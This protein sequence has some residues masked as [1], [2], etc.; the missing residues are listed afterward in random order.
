VSR[1]AATGPSGLLIRPAAPDEL[2]EV[3]AL[4]VEA[5]VADA[6]IAAEHSYTSILAGTSARAAGAELYV[7]EL[8]GRLVGTVTFCPPG[9]PYR[10]VGGDGQ[11]EFRMLG[12]LPQARGHG[13]ARALVEH[14]FDRCRS[15]G[16]GELVLCTMAEMAAARALYDSM[17]FVR[18]PELDFMP[19]P[20]V[21]LIAYRATVG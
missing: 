7:A 9:S 11:G 6:H 5:Y 8:D 3:G 10:E 4:T 21:S 2:D 12:V 14:C 16:L 19:E 15:L 20:T 18:A 17:G 1:H 13:I